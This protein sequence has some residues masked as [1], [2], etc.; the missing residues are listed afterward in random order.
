[1]MV[2][3]LMSMTLLAALPTAAF[4]VSFTG[5]PEIDGGTAVAAIAL[6]GGA[7]L[8]LRGRRRK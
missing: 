7:A 4:A 1:M 8:V 3:I 6:L 5:A 2:K